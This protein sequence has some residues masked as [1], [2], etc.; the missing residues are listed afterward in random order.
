MMNIAFFAPTYALGAI[1]WWRV[2]RLSAMQ[3]LSVYLLLSLALL[4]SAFHAMTLID[5]DHRYRL[6]LLPVL[7]MLAALGLEAARRPP[8]YR[9]AS[10]VTD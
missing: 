9:G 4:I 5:Y 8:P 3:Q 10:R 6:P 2:R 7:M 1:A